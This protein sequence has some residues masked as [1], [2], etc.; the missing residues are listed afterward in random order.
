MKVICTTEG[1]PNKGIEVN[2]AIQEGMNRIV[3]CCCGQVF[4]DK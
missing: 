1:C 3:I 2:V 4:E